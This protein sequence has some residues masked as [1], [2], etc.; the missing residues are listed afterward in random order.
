MHFFRLRKNVPVIESFYFLFELH[1]SIIVI[2][3]T[4]HW[5]TVRGI[6]I[7]FIMVHMQKHTNMHTLFLV[8]LLKKAK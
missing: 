3:S 7:L 1:Q 4:A 5:T 6:D 2:N 8:V